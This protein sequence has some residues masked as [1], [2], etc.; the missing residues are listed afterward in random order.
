[1]LQAEKNRTKLMDINEVADFLEIS[2][3]TVRN[4]IKHDY[5]APAKTEGK[6]RFIFQDV[7][8][9]KDNLLNGNINRLRKRANKNK[10][11]STF[12]PIEYLTDSEKLKDAENVIN[13]I[14]THNVEV[15]EGLFFLAL[16]ILVD[17]GLIKP[18]ENIDTL[19]SFDDSFFNHRQIKKEIQ[20]WAEKIKFKSKG[21]FQKKIMSVHIPHVRDFL[22]VIYQ[23]LSK[24]GNKAEAGSYYT[25]SSIAEGIV[26]EYLPDQCKMVLDPCCGTGQFLLFAADILSQLGNKRVLEN[27]WGCDIDELAVRIARLNLL[28][29]CK[30]QEEISP[31]VYCLNSIIEGS[32]IFSSYQSILKENFFDLIITNPPWGA[33]IAKSEINQLSSLFPFI[34][35]GE[36][37]SYF[38]AKGM[39]LLKKEG[40]LSYILPESFLNVKMH[41]DVR[42]Y[43]LKNSTLKK[44][45]F[46]DRVFKNVFTP[47]IRFDIQKTQ[48]PRNHKIEVQNGKT[49]KIAQDELL[50]NENFEISI[51]IDNEDA[52]ILKKIFSQK[53]TT[54]A[55]NAEW[56]LGIVTGNNDKFLSEDKKEGREGII[57]GKDIMK[58]IYQPAQCFLKFEPAQFQQ[59]APEQ[60][61]RSKEKLIYRFIS[62]QLVFA[63]DD[64]QILTLN[65]A[66]ILIPQSSTH[67]IKVILGLF[68]SSLYQFI[69]HKKFNSIKVLRNHIESLPLPGWS[70]AIYKNIVSFV[71]RL[72]CFSLDQ[73]DRIC[74]FNELDKYIMFQWGLTENEIQHVLKNVS[75]IK[76]KGS[77]WKNLRKN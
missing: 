51:T 24:E 64:K 23:S 53:H 63:Y 70:E 67:S 27:V 30:D 36:A 17:D 45:L 11:S 7:H 56:A 65:S 43:L 25:P 77:Q 40:V 58:F 44:I 16:K 74:I 28:L 15:E 33:K 29:N 38:L 37:F 22:G 46:L 59:T 34:K 9:L 4:W 55:N 75:N 73:E 1:M 2:S 49:F 72:I 19:L 52:R 6:M 31:H 26:K 5:I 13:I 61:Y 71:D 18:I 62:K 47:V 48:F 12:L 57:K 14:Y 54:L 66:N 21:D 41:G 35:S 32:D 69:S 8:S 50:K 3:A 10:S 68:N 60:K 76:T 39:R 42:E 20:A